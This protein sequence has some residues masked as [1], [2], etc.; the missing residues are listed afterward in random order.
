MRRLFGTIGLTYL[1]VLAVAY[2][3]YSNLTVAVA[4]VLGAAVVIAGVVRGI[5]RHT[6]Y[7]E[8]V[9]AGLSVLAAALSIFLYW[10]IVYQ[11]VINNY[12]DKEISFHG[13]ICDDIL[14]SERLTI[15]PIRTET[16]NGE[17]CRTRLSVTFYYDGGWEPFDEVDGRMTV[18]QEISHSQISKGCFLQANQ[19]ERT[20]LRST[21][22]HHFSVYQYA[23][24]LR[25]WIKKQF[26]V[27]LSRDCAGLCRAVFLGDKLALNRT[28]RFDFSRTGTTYL[29]V[30]S[31][32]HLSIICGIVAAL[33]RPIRKRRLLT[34]LIMLS[35]IVLFSALTG[36]TRS[37]LRS[38]IML[39]LT[40][41]GGIARR[42]YDSINAMGVAAVLLTAGNPFAAGDWGVLFS[43]AATMGIVL[44]SRK[45]DRQI[46]RFLHIGLIP[47]G[48]IRRALHAAV[49]LF[50]VS[51]AASL[52]VLPLSILAFQRI[53]PLVVVISCLTSPLTFLMMVGI[54]ILLGLSL[55]P[56]A[57]VLTTWAA[58]ALEEICRLHLLVNHLFAVIPFSSV[59]ADKPFLMVWIIASV[60][61]VAVGYLIHAGKRYVLCAAAVSLCVLTA[62]WSLTA[63][64][65]SHPAELMIF[66]SGSGTTVAV[67]KDN[68]LSLLSAGGAPSRLT[69]AIDALYTHGDLI[70]NM[71]VPNRTNYAGNIEALKDYFDIHQTLVNGDSAD[72]VP[73]R[74]AYRIDDGTAFSLRLN[75]GTTEEVLCIDKTVYQYLKV[76]GKT[77][78]FMPH[79][80]DSERLPEQYRSADI[81]I[82]DFVC[83]HPEALHCHELIYT[84]TKNKRL[85]NHLDLLYEISDEVTLLTNGEMI[86]T[87]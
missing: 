69:S 16:I 83:Q 5:L 68:N 67:G 18:I 37:V 77:L 65:D 49:N 36:F 86:I 72:S 25:G 53:S 48:A 27:T 14:T 56:F 87:I 58:V 17:A 59:R 1:T 79:G 6:Y 85:Q 54:L 45:I 29:I 75:S 52:W 26:S 40:H 66:S 43:F 78:L 21:G 44:W 74:D 15:V 9:A 20:V 61:L 28:A 13:Y 84:G 30:V 34:M 51:L 7:R 23:V 70:D 41:C 4:A 47:F 35:V 71:I 12:S 63:L 64:L 80:G 8:T 24:A 55:I 38:G 73:V 57:G 31:G 2:F 81:I 10:N 62:G 60:V 82:M 3:F 50:C 11:P 19:D 42:K 46:Y 39:I 76:N 33:C 32:L 22:A